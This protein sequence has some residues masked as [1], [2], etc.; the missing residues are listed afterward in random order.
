M[1]PGYKHIETLI[2]FVQRVQEELH[3]VAV[4]LFGSLAKGNYYLHSDADVCVI[5]ARPEVPWAEGYERVAALDPEGVI[6]PMVYGSDQFLRMIRDLNALALEVCHD[7]W[8]LAGDE[9]YIRSLEETFVKTKR[10][11]GLEKTE[12]GWLVRREIGGAIGLRGE[13]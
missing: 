13:V 1:L 2:S 3:P 12:G 6:Q 5:L 9:G 7:G 10:L 11:Y 8:V 4:V